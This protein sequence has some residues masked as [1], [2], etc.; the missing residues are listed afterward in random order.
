[1]LDTPDTPAAPMPILADRPPVL[2]ADNPAALAARD[3]GLRRNG[4]LAECVGD[5]LAVALETGPARIEL[6][7]WTLRR[8]HSAVGMHRHPWWE[9]TWLLRGSLLYETET[10]AEPH[11]GAGPAA[12]SDSVGE[13]AVLPLRPG[14]ACLIP[15]GV[16]HRWRTDSDWLVLFGLMI[17]WPHAGSAMIA[18]PR[19]LP[20]D[21]GQQA[22]L[23]RLAFEARRPRPH[24][25]PVIRGL[26]EALLG[27]ALRPVS[28]SP[29]RSAL[30]D[31]AGRA[32]AHAARA[33]IQQHLA[34][35]LSAG[36]IAN[37]FDLSAR[38]LNRLLGEHFG[39]STGR[40]IRDLRLQRAARLLNDPDRS[41]KSI[42]LMAGFQDPDYFTR[43]FTQVH[44][45]PPSAYRRQP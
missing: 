11:P 6:A 20:A 19:P 17:D 42:A 7:H 14:Q 24:G 10:E 12:E 5:G 37:Q 41:I 38:H 21:P 2:E 29:P 30:P 39:C 15:P 16:A 44:G 40:L 28:T 34:E 22:L 45:H 32:T 26:L 9:I 25:R 33:F 23:R 3:H 36:I 13:P 35:P 43:L 1:M 8:G 4:P 27:L 31:T 18:D